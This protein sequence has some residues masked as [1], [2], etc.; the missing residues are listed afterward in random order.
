[1]SEVTWSLSIVAEGDFA[2]QRKVVLAKVSS[3]FKVVLL[4]VYFGCYTSLLRKF[5]CVPP[6]DSIRGNPGLFDYA[7]F[8]RF[9]ISIT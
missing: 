1:M 9:H 7:T 2:R 4:D 3:W 6:L 8:W 5:I